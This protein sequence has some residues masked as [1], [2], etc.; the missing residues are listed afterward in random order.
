[1]ET[2][3]GHEGLPRDQ[4]DVGV[5]GEGDRGSTR[6]HGELPGRKTRRAGVLP[7]QGAGSGV[8]GLEGDSNPG[9][10]P[11]DSGDIL[12]RLMAARGASLPCDDRFARE[13]PTLWRLL[14]VR[15]GLSA[16]GKNSTS[17]TILCEGTAYTVI[18]TVK[19]AGVSAQITLYTLQGLTKALDTALRDPQTVW[20]EIRRWRAKKD[21]FGKS[22]KAGG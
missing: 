14:T 3:N 9:P 11:D 8:G 7:G 15:D 5:P 1:M 17:I 2:S 20:R 21:A 22:E 18:V 10:G 13:H 6:G 19:S 4:I 16:D 12:A